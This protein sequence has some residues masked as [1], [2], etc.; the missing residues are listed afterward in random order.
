MDKQRVK[1]NSDLNEEKVKSA[2]RRCLAAR[3]FS[4][5]LEPPVLRV[6]AIFVQKGIANK[7]KALI[8]IFRVESAVIQI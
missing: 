8:N 4:Q 7:E 1:C 2:L 3:A 6:A 5:R